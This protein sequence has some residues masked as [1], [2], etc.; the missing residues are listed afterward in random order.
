MVLVFTLVQ[1]SVASL[2]LHKWQFDMWS[3]DVTLA[4]AMEAAGVP[5]YGELR[6]GRWEGERGRVRGERMGG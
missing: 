5:G 4:N 1:S 3:N 6:M 2:G